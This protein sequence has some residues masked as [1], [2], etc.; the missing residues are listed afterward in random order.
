MANVTHHGFVVL[1]VWEGLPD[2]G[3]VVGCTRGAGGV[4][5]TTGH[6]CSAGGP[7]PAIVA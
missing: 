2:L 5:G 7:L 6:G 3:W 1:V 4:A